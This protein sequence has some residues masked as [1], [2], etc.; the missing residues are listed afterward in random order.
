MG[1]PLKDS[2]MSTGEGEGQCRFQMQPDRG[3][4]RVR[5]GMAGRLI[6][7]TMWKQDVKVDQDVAQG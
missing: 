4:V 5:V 2:L 1:N 3:E 7:I 6:R